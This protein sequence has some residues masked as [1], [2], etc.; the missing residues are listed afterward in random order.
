MPAISLIRLAILGAFFLMSLVKCHPNG[1][2][3]GC[4][5][6]KSSS[7]SKEELIDCLSS[8]SVLMDA[9]NILKLLDANR[10]GLLSLEEYMHVAQ[11]LSRDGSSNQ[12]HELFEDTAYSSDGSAR[13][14]HFK[15]RHGHEEFLSLNELISRSNENSL[16]NLKSVRKK[17][18]NTGEEQT[19]L[20]QEYSGVVR[21]SPEVD[22]MPLSDASISRDVSD[23][24]IAEN[25]KRNKYQNNEFDFTASTFSTSS[26]PV[27]E[28]KSANAA[29]M[30]RILALCRFAHKELNEIG[31][32]IGALKQVKTLPYGGTLRQQND[33]IDFHDES[34]VYNQSESYSVS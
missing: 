3:I 15:D 28:D 34:A 27:D 29:G 2:F 7:L 1:F 22:V 24:N 19:F 5:Y 21:L 33:S 14:I 20:M 6:D 11:S 26:P 31:L 30:Q 16:N 4:D 25:G 9:D 17:S 12:D 13:S 8:T 23:T 10:D 18:A 32:A